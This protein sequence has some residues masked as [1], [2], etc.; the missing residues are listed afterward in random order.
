MKFFTGGIFSR[1]RFSV[2]L[3]A[4]ESSFLPH[5]DLDFSVETA[6]NWQDIFS[7][8]MEYGGTRRAEH[9]FTPGSAGRTFDISIKNA[10]TLIFASRAKPYTDERGMTAF[11]IPHIGI[12]EPVLYM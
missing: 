2:G 6:P 10:G 11:D 7:L 1:L 9:R 4:H 12:V 8:D 3:A 5:I